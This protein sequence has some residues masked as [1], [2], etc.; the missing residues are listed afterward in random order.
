MNTERM[1]KCRQQKYEEAKAQKAQIDKQ[2]AL[3]QRPR[4]SAQAQK[5]AEEE[6]R[7]HAILACL[8]DQREGPTSFGMPAVQQFLAA[9]MLPL[10]DEQ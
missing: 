2:L 8:Y 6:M 4:V 9:V 7:D 3:I 1:Q 10:S 5:D